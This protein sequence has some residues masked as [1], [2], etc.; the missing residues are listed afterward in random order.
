MIGGEWEMGSEDVELTRV[1]YSSKAAEQ[2]RKLSRVKDR[3]WANERDILL[4]QKKFE[5]I[6]QLRVKDWRVQEDQR[7]KSYGIN[8]AKRKVMWRK[9]PH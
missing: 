7:I 8:K 9:I 2:R 6:Y 5:Y 3:A 4:E 1:E